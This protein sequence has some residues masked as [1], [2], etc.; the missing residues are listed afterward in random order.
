MHTKDKHKQDK[1]QE[2]ELKDV[3]AIDIV[4]QWGNKANKEQ[5]VKPLPSKD[6]KEMPF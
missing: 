6:K 4:K 5:Q 1:H 2:K 3:T